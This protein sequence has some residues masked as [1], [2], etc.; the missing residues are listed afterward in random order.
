MRGIEIML[1]WLLEDH[2]ARSDE[3]IRQDKFE[4]RRK[5]ETAIAFHS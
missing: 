1:K 2:D 5:I 4:A 3:F